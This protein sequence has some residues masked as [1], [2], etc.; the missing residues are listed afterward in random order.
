MIFTPTVTLKDTEI[1]S[2]LPLSPAVKEEEDA[3]IDAIQE[4][5]NSGRGSSTIWELEDGGQLLLIHPDDWIEYYGS[6]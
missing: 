5:I 6:E 3:I 4:I 2:D 1:V